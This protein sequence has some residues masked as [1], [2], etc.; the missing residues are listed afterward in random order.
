MIVS[1]VSTFLP[2]G[3]QV[4][5]G[6]ITYLKRKVEK[7][8]SYSCLKLLSIVYPPPPKEKKPVVFLGTS[9]RMSGEGDSKMTTDHVSKLGTVVSSVVT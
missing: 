5:G 2:F 8:L 1:S 9:C 7:F 4:Q 6:P 3:A